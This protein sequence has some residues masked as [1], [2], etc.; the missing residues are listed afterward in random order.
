MDRPAHILVVDDDASICRTLGLIFERQG[1]ETETAG[2]GRD[3]IQRVMERSFD[4][5]FLDVKLPDMEGIELL[6]PLRER[7]PDIGVQMITGHA[8]LESALEALNAGASAY[9]LKPL[10]M[11]EVLGA[12]RELLEKQRLVRE[13][14]RLYEE[15][16]RELM[17]RRRAEEALEKLNVTLEDRVECRTFELQVLYELSQQIG[18]TVSYDELFRL[19]LEHL[20][21]AVPYD[22]SAGLLVRGETGELFLKSPRALSPDVQQKIRDRLIRGF[23]RMNG[24]EIPSESI[25]TM[26]LAE[27]DQFGVSLDSLGSV[28][29]VPLIVGPDSAMVGLLFVGAEQEG[30]FTE[31]QVRLLYTV[32]NQASVSIQRLRTLLAEE[33]ERLEVLVERLPEGLILLD[34]ELRIVLVNPTAR[35]CLPILTDRSVGDTLPALGGWPMEHLLTPPAEGLHH[36][37]RVNGAAS[38]VF[39]VEGRSMETGPVAGGS[40][41]VLRDVTEE[42]EL[43]SRMEQQER[44]ASVGQLAAGIAH[45]F[46]N[47]LTGVIGYAQLLKMDA[48]VSDSTKSGLQT[49][50]QQGQRAAHLIRQIL[51]FS[52]QSVMQRQA[53]DLAPF[54]K[55]TVKFLERTIPEH[56]RIVLEMEPGSYSIHADLAQIQDVVTNLA[57]NARDAMP[58]GGKLRFSLAKYS[59][60]PDDASP[61]PDMPPGKWVMLSVSD[62]GTGIPPEIRSRIFDPFFT[63]KERG[64]GTG[65]GL[66]QVHGIVTQHGGFIDVESRV[67]EETTFVLY[68]PEARL[69]GKRAGE[70]SSEEFA[71]GQGQTILV[72]EDE[73]IVLDMIGEMLDLLGYRARLARSAEEALEL[74]ERHGDEIVLV[75]TDVVMPGMSGLTLFRV[76]KA[77]DPDIKIAFMSGYAD[78]EGKALVSEG[79]VSWLQK[80][81]DMSTLVA[82]MEKVFG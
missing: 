76:L 5:A 67:G 57:V 33:Q 73:P 37:V 14:R 32:A 45:D 30:A 49:I 31:D 34:K 50:E 36:E 11:D 54:L 15:A 18:Y 22:V 61:L 80:P 23:A 51:D 7:H 28:F 70:E 52:R 68:L 65:L 10:N 16:Q 27:D 24:S 20:H 3:A 62:T 4:V 77:K 6:A 17:E 56:I 12:I 44:L 26:R 47:L 13:N 21:R 38:R 64:E 71:R 8:S 19:M 69:G 60:E 59:L 55:E 66:A 81:V 79:V 74:Y 29:Q 39:E 35:E 40:V 25:R 75:L 63:T 46:N 72:A 58:E 43:H 1:Y 82:L 2:T 9:I 41:L 48:D 78:D 53:F 42:R